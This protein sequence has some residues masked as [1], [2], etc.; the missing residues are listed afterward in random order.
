MINTGSLYIYKPDDMAE[1]GFIQVS[2]STDTNLQEV[3]DT[4][5]LKKAEAKYEADMKKIDKKDRKYDSDLAS[6]ETERNA[7]KQEME[8]LKTVAKENVERTFRLFS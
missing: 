1:D 8:T 3:S 7:I 6:L 4:S 5:I 2:V